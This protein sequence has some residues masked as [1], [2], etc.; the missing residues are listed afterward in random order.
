METRINPA[1]G[2]LPISELTSGRLDAFYR[3][4][5]ATGLSASSVRQVHAVLRRGLTQ[6][7]KWGWLTVNPAAHAT[8]PRLD[9]LPVDPPDRDVVALLLMFA[10]EFDPDFAALLRVAAA[11]GARRG[12]LCGLRWSDINWDDSSL[13]IARSVIA[14]TASPVVATDATTRTTMKSTKTGRAR[15]I[16]LDPDTIETLRHYRN[17]RVEAADA[18]RIVLPID[19]YMF[20]NDV[21]GRDPLHPDTLTSRFRT[22]CQRAAVAEFARRSPLALKAVNSVAGQ[23]V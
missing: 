6:A 20:T 16:A 2:K 9:H 18:C 4:L 5:Q 8:P 3:E 11:T 22:V 15:R 17:R 10:V 1:V 19:G 12:E 13:F 21:D 14:A 23:I 7:V